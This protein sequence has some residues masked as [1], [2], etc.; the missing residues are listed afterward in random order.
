MSGKNLSSFGMQE[1]VEINH[2]MI[3]AVLQKELFSEA[4][5][6]TPSTSD[7]TC[8]EESLDPNLQL[9][10][11]LAIETIKHVNHKVRCFEVRRTYEQAC[12]A[13]T[14]VAKKSHKTSS[15]ETA[16]SMENGRL[17]QLFI[18]SHTQKIKR[19]LSSLREL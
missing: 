16:E 15:Q 14:Y 12:C 2:Q 10:F 6:D 18:P 13:V 19:F 4:A 11:D 17:S 1:F 9:C 8:K 5:A 7:E 3:S